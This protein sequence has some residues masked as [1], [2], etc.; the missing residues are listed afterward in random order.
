LCLYCSIPDWHHPYYPNQG[1][2]HELPGPKPGDRPDLLAFVEV[3]REQVRELCTQYGEIHGFW[4]DNNVD[5]HVD[6][7]LNALIRELQPNCIINDRGFDPGDFGTPERDFDPSLDALSGFARPTE[8]C[9]S[10]GMESWGYRA[11]EDYYSD[12]HLQRSLAKY[13][14]RGGNYLLNVGPKADGAI[15]IEAERIL[16]RLGDWYVRVRPA[17]LGEPCSTLTDNR[18]VLLTR[19]GDMLYVICHR[20]MAG[21]AV[22]LRPL[23]GA[24]KRATLLNDGRAVDFAVELLPSDHVAGTACLRL[25]RLPVNELAGQV[26]VMAL[27]FDRLPSAGG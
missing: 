12:L 21:D 10:V 6:P 16:R 4:W 14:A 7:S 20:E 3:L 18:D 19:R 13:L 22:K 15:P 23:T 24:P 1:R 27:E 26:L 11:D 5:E 17:L 8:A 2:H 9:Q 25:K